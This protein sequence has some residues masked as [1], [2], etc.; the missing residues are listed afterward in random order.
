MTGLFQIIK[1]KFNIDRDRGK[2][3]RI[4]DCF[5]TFN[6]EIPGW[7]GNQSAMSEIYNCSH[8]AVSNKTL[9]LVPVSER[10]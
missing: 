6:D 2:I 8:D 3:P 7:P 1:I 4:T 9:I 5:I 10:K